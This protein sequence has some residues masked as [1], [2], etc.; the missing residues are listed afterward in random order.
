MSV[1]LLHTSEQKIYIMPSR[2]LAASNYKKKRICLELL[3]RNLRDNEPFDK[4]LSIGM[5]M[6][7]LYCIP[8]DDPA[9]MKLADTFK[10]SRD[11]QN[12][13]DLSG[14]ESN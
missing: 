14:D 6:N 9:F 2:V 1:K 4:D 7:S 11:S 8:S 3:N 10:L 13:Q 12:E 5:I